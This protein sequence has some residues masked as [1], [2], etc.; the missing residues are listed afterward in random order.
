MSTQMRGE[1]ATEEPCRRY[2]E[3]AALCQQYWQ[4]SD[5]A[6]HLTVWSRVNTNRQLHYTAIQLYAARMQDN[7]ILNITR[8]AIDPKFHRVSRDFD[9]FLQR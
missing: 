6:D 9:L 2:L 7:S 4:Y 3:T 1:F 5:A 8:R